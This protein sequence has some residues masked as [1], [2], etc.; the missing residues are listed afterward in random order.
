[1]SGWTSLLALGCLGEMSV[2][3]SRSQ[4]HTTWMPR[5][6]KVLHASK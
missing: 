5:L 2:R 4:M 6:K 3:M 1:M